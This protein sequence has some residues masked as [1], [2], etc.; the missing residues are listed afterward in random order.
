[1][2]ASFQ[3]LPYYNPTTQLSWLHAD[4]PCRLI[5]LACYLIRRKA[6]LKALGTEKKNDLISDFDVLSLSVGAISN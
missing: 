4:K 6:K 3:E 5:Q 1:M 2:T